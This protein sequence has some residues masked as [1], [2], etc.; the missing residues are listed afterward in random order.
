[1]LS[2]LGNGFL[3]ADAVKWVPVGA[4]PNTATWTP[5]IPEAKDYR[6][7]ARWTAHS[8]RAT[9]AT[10]TVTHD[11]GA[12]SVTVNQQQNTGTWNLLGT[13]RFVPGAGHN[14]RLTD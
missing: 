3:I 13:F 8:N 14:V 6:V 2:D 1:V 7:H 12:T 4:A 9:N 11:A 10:Y 5:I